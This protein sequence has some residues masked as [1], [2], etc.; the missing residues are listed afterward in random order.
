[1]P[2]RGIGEGIISG[3]KGDQMNDRNGCPSEDHHEGKTKR[4]YTR[5]SSGESK[6]AQSKD[7]EE[8]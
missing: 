2:T 8:I 5:T 7:S 4:T 3:S 6:P 1:M